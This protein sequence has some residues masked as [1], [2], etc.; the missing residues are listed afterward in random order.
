M[1]L[2]LHALLMRVHMLPSLFSIAFSAI[3][4]AI[5]DCEGCGKNR[6]WSIL[7]Y[8]RSI[9]LKGLRKRTKDFSQD[10]RLLG[11]GSNSGSSKYDRRLPID[12]W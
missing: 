3:Y 1:N 9:C 2:R 4:L 12:Y 10:R 11:R 8:D 5:E 7:R 6:P